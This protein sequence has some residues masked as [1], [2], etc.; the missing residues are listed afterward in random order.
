[1]Y[2]EDSVFNPTRKSNPFITDTMSEIN[3]DREKN[4]IF[5]HSMAK[6]VFNDLRNSPLKQ[7]LPENLQVYDPALEKRL[8]AKEATMKPG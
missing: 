3:D 7:R 4:V 8:F 2:D 6:G 1:M 5:S